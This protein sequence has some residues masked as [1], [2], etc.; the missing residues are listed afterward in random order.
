MHLA[1]SLFDQVDRD[2]PDSGKGLAVASAQHLM[3]AESLDQEAAWETET[4]KN[5]D[6]DDKG[7]KQD[8]DDKAQ[9]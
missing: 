6:K 7:T 4:A 8:N 2:V 1:L 3:V 9:K 5:M